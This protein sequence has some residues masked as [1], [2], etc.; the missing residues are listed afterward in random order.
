M[1]VK[2][3]R[4][5][6]PIVLISI[7]IFSACKKS[8]SAPPEVALTV[9]AVSPATGPYSTSV[10]I[11]GTGFDATSSK[12][13]F[14]GIA[15]SVQTVTAT[16]IVAT[17]PKGAGTGPVTV[18]AGTRTIKGPDFTYQYTMATSTLAGNANQGY[19]DGSGTAADFNYVGGLATDAQGNLYVADVYNNRIR[20]ITPAGVVTTVAGD[21]TKGF[22]DGNSASSEFNNPYGVAV[23]GSGNIYVADTYNYAIRKITPAGIVSTIAGTGSAG[24]ADGSGTAAKFSL[25]IRLTLDAQ[26]NLFVADAQNQRIRKVTVS[27]VVTTIAGDGVF[28]EIDANGT[29]A[30]LGGPFDVTLDPQGN[31]FVC[32]IDNRIRKISP[33]GDVTTFAGSAVQGTA[34][35]MGA[36]AQF[37]LPQGIATDAQGNIYVADQYNNRIRKITQSG[38]VTT[39]LGGNAG[40][41]DGNGTAALFYRPT[42]I[43]FDSKGTM[44]VADLGNNVVR[45]VVM[46]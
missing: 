23:D 27:G 28:G 16:Q 19:A 7:G 14:N 36:A 46:E 24:F 10:T 18:Q 44:Y 39:Y 37:Y 25:P 17:V 20:K 45:K 33:G 15:A 12:V 34:D 41:V 3:L 26:G 1:P 43:A 8:D 35:G 40:Y 29:S 11:T 21:G 38:Q 42:S 32:G 2:L 4:Q 5:L 13:L 22:V 6:I 9:S 31:L 30:E